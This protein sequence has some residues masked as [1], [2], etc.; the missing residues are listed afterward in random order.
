MGYKVS[1]SHAASGS[2]KTSAPREDV[3]N[4]FRAW[5]ETNP[6]KM[7]NVSEQSPARQLLAK[8]KT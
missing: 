7:G 5:I 1:R 3:M 4:V 8:S 2:I 6:V